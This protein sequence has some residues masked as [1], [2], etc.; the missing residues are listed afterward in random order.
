MQLYGK[1]LCG[2]VFLFLISL[3]EKERGHTILFAVHSHLHR[4]EYS[5]NIFSF[6]VILSGYKMLKK[7]LL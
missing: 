6:S 7:D 5:E 3:R 2:F 1:V 4:M